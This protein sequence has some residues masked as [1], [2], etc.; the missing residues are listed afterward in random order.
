MTYRKRI[1]VLIGVPTYLD[2]YWHSLPY[3]DGDINGVDGLKATLEKGLGASCCFDEVKAPD[4]SSTNRELKDLLW[5]ICTDDALDERCLTLIYFS[6]HGALDRVSRLPSLVVHN[7]SYS[8]PDGTGVS[9]SWLEKLI[10]RSRSSLVLVLDACFA[11]GL[12][13]S[14]VSRE[15]FDSAPKAI[16]ASCAAD[17][18][19]FASADGKQ[20]RFTRNLIMG[21]RGEAAEYGEVTVQSL[22]KY[23]VRSLQ[24]TGQKPV[25]H[26]PES[27]LR[28]SVPRHPAEARSLQDTEGLEDRRSCVRKLVTEYSSLPVFEG[29]GHF[30]RP[31]VRAFRVEKEDEQ[32]E[33]QFRRVSLSLDEVREM[34]S[35]ATAV[36]EP[37]D[38]PGD[39]L[40]GI[41]EWAKRLSPLLVLQGDTGTGKTTLLQKTWLELARRWLDGKTARFPLLIDLR[42][43][44]DVRLHGRSAR[45]GVASFVD[46]KRKFRSVLM[47]VLQNE[48]GL[49]LFWKDLIALCEGGKVVLLLDGLDE[50]SQDGRRESITTHLRLVGVLVEAGA[51]VAL[52]CRTH[53]LRSDAELLSVIKAA[54]LPWKNAFLFDLV[55]FEPRQ[56]E[57]YVS[58]RLSQSKW[59]LWRQL[60]ETKS[61]GVGT[62]S[63]RP[64][65][66]GTLIQVLSESGSTRGVRQTQL[67]ESY[68]QE[69]LARDRWRFEQFLGDFGPVIDRDLSSAL[70]SGISLTADPENDLEAWCEEL[71][72]GFVKS[73]ALEMR[74][75]GRKSLLADEIANFLRT[76]LPSLPDVFLSF[77]DYAIRTC[78]FL[79][80]NKEGHYAFL[81]PSVRAFFEAAGI[82]QELSRKTY[83]W[84]GSETR[85]R[86]RLA[87]IPHSLGAQPLDEDVADF[88]AEMVNPTDG[89]ALAS[90][91][92]DT[93]ERVRACPNTLNYLAGNCLTLLARLWGEP[94]LEGERFEG[95]NLSGAQLRRALLRKVSFQDSVFEDAG[96]E[97][98]TFEEVKL[99]GAKFVRCAF[100]SARF[101]GVRINGGAVVRHCSGLTT[102]KGVPVEFTNAQTLS[103]KGQ[104][105]FERR[106]VPRVTKMR[107]LEGDSFVA[108]G[109]VAAANFADAW[110]SPEHEVSVKAF[111]IDVAPVT[112][113]QFQDFVKANPEWGK[114]AVIDRL[115][116]AYYLKEWD[117]NAPPPDRDD[118]P[119]VYVSW[120]AAEAYARWVGKRLPTEAEWE[121]ALRDGRHDERLRYPWG[122]EIED[123][124]PKYFKL[125]REGK[126][127]RPKETPTTP[128][129]QLLSMSGNVNEWVADWFSTEYFEALRR[130]AAQG[131]AEENPPGPLFGTERVYRG[132]SFLSGLDGDAHEFTCFYRSRLFPQNTNQDMGFRCALDATLYREL[133]AS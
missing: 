62:L 124:P 4:P 125:I 108:S 86:S 109:G 81:H 73:M 65:L 38:H 99:N 39:A 77:F 42:L 6:G 70:A 56:I 116:N 48:Y 87:A 95:L 119:V 122:N 93:K 12:P 130:K 14:V 132:G 113:R 58:Q 110:E 60:K 100:D 94:Q 45:S 85:G 76:K 1:A 127:V 61:L 68:L 128:N 117:E 17:E 84:D 64:F 41:L 18:K 75:S 106:R 89:V 5:K 40:D 98:A 107:L 74:L 3:V 35:G 129:Y 32:A 28:L 92:H 25:C 34:D 88:L 104:R 80:R 131:E 90:L 59:G 105:T 29:P 133:E 53:Y 57:L 118:E 16:L 7:T 19:S 78:S 54:E 46:A 101:G 2:E 21:L 27:P 49:G 82:R 112:N 43:L 71:I 33:L 67:F 36:D 26:V 111:A 44:A 47:D 50:M 83:P 123:V 69:W 72:S 114:Q 79:T 103:A 126:I 63:S 10:S 24:D 55:P 96:F 52:S 15:L 9:F 11:G 37:D 51:K 23:L 120:F 22:A 8:D 91:I 13:E 97:H 102:A 31:H 20:S 30:V 121:F 66:L 115:K